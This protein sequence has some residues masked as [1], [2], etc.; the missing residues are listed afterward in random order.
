M[1]MRECI[2]MRLKQI[3]K[4]QRGFTLVEMLCAVLVLGFLGLLLNSGIMMAVRNYHEVT[5]VSEAQVLLSTLSDA[6]L[7]DLRYARQVQTVDDKLVSY[8]SD[9]YGSNTAF[10]LNDGHPLAAGQR[11]L[12]PGAY[13]NGRY[14]LPDLPEITYKDG[15]FNVSLRVQ[16]TDGG[17]FAENTFS[18]YCLNSAA[19]EAPAP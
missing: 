17:I 19:P 2:L 10:S 11:V 12:P 15:C 5:A 8:T 16:E 7:D 4:N 6:L 18:V 9:S 13:D 14:G 3:L 1:V